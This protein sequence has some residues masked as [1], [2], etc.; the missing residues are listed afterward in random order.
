MPTAD[1][2]SD[3]PPNLRCGTIQ[4][5]PRYVECD[6]MGYVHHS[7]YPVWFEMGRTELLRERGLRYR[8]LEEQGYLLVVAKLSLTYRR[9]ARYDDQLTL[10]T[11]I[12]RQTAVRI[13]HRY[14]VHRDHELLTT[15]ESTLACVNRSGVLVPLPSVLALPPSKPPQA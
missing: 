11:T 3:L 4:I 1:P 13:E 12:A 9:P 6:P 10:T 2:L 5:R 8:D 15:A 7:I 14:E